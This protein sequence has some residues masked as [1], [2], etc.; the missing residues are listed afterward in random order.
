MGILFMLSWWYGKG[1][2][3]ALGQ[4]GRE[5]N[6][7]GK[8]FAVSIL[9]KTLFAPWKQITSPSSFSNFFQSAIDNTIS[10][11]IGFIIRSCILFIALLWT[12]VVIISGILL[13]ILWPFIPLSIFILPFLAI[14]GVTL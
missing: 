2:V 11:T 3:W 6:H 13:I 10:R 14:K 1:W 7:V 8:V 9:L 5:V 4:I 12:S